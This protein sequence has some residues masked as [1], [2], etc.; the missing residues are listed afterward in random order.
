MQAGHMITP[1]AVTPVGA[2]AGEEI[3]H[4]DYVY[5]ARGARIRTVQTWEAP[6]PLSRVRRAQIAFR[7]NGFLVQGTRPPYLHIVF[8]WNRT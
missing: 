5:V 7:A 2:R 1:S 8:Q 3:R 6:A 4:R